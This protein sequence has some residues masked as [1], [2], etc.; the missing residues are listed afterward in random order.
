MS[1]LFACAKIKA[2]ANSLKN[3]RYSIGYQKLLRGNKSMLGQVQQ[4]ALRKATFLHAIS[5]KAISFLIIA[6]LILVV[7]DA[8]VRDTYFDVGFTSDGMAWVGSVAAIEVL[9]FIISHIRYKS[10]LQSDPI[11]SAGQDAERILFEVRDSHGRHATLERI[12]RDNRAEF[13]CDFYEIKTQERLGKLFVWV[14]FIILAASFTPRMLVYQQQQ[15]DRI[16][17]YQSAEQAVSEVWLATDSCGSVMVS[18]DGTSNRYSHYTKCIVY[19]NDGVEFSADVEF[20]E[21][22]EI[23]NFGYWIDIDDNISEFPHLDDINTIIQSLVDSLADSSLKVADSKLFL[24]DF[25][26]NQAIIDELAENY[27]LKDYRKTTSC[28]SN[29]ADCNII[30][31][32][33]YSSNYGNTTNYFYLEMN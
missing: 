11:T 20:N 32:Y 21:A 18:D 9:I 15:Q 6:P 29:V 1:G 3:M 4:K 10:L 16:S 2:M 19:Y 12:A 26:I 23:A 25:T 33:Y 14:L 8:F 22:Y 28:H 17:N 7:A 24:N 13:L 31:Q 27:Y 30:Y 5:A